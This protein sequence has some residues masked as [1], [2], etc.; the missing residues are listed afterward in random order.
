ML[1]ADFRLWHQPCEYALHKPRRE[2][3]KSAK[4]FENKQ[5]GT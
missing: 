1:F 2:Q 4:D 3:N 5:E